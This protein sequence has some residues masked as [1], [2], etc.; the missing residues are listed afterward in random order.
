MNWCK[1]HDAQLAVVHFG[2]VWE[3]AASLR[4]AGRIDECVFV[5]IKENE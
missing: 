1:V 4:T 3:C 2:I 5:L